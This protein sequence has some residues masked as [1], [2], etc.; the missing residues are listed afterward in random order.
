M[1]SLAPTSDTYLEPLDDELARRLADAIC[2]DDHL[3]C[4]WP[5]CGCRS[6]KQKINAAAVIVATEI[7]RIKNGVRSAFRP[8]AER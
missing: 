3:V 4:S 2:G 8:K 1:T 6:T 5:D 7:G